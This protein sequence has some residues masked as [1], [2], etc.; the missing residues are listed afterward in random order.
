MWIW[1][2]QQC[3]V[4]IRTICWKQC[5]TLNSDFSACLISIQVK[6]IVLTGHWFSNWNQPRKSLTT[7]CCLTRQVIAPSKKLQIKTPTQPWCTHTHTGVSH[8]FGWLELFSGLRGHEEKNMLSVNCLPKCH[9][10]L[11]HNNLHSHGSRSLFSQ[12]TMFAANYSIDLDSINLKMSHRSE[13]L[14]DMK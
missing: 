10:R 9:D 6:C 2:D 3:H 1:L 5:K 11:W 8:Y 13:K 4:A 7:I 12:Q 14:K